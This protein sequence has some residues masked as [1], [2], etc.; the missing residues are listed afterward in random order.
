[1]GQGLALAL[2]RAGWMV[3]LGARKRKDVVAESTLVV[4][5]LARTIAGAE[6]VLLAVPDDVITELAGGLA[7]SG[8]VLPSQIFLHL[9]GARDRSA[10]APL[11]DRAGGLGSF[12]PLQ[13]VAD[14]ARAPEQLTGAYAGIEGDAA[15]MAA[16]GRIAGALGMI[17]V[18]IPAAG[19]ALAHAGAVMAANYSAALL[20][21]AER[22]AR[23]AGIDAALAGRVYLPLA[24][25]AL[26]NV[27]SVGAM[28]AL[29]GP[30]RR[31]DI[32]TIRTHLA[33]LTGTDRELYRV[34]GLETLAVA[35]RAGLAPERAALLRQLL[36]SE[37]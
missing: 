21:V 26:A 2:S 10:L 4:N 22:L 25:A 30:I 24:Q 37:S 5:D 13:T 9:S 33:V 36:R 32:E 31:G 29:T 6:I 20:D 12:W 17:A 18:P 19:K 7:A 11:A 1:M 35:E 34:L 27:A 15:A 23:A 28:A 16:G 8:A 14:P 3:I